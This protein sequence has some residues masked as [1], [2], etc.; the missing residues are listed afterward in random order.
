MNKKEDSVFEN[1]IEEEDI[2][3]I[4]EEDDDE[5]IEDEDID[6]GEEVLEDLEDIDDEEEVLEDIEDDILVDLDDLINTI[7]EEEQEIE[8]KISDKR[9]TF[10]ILTKYEKVF[11]LG[12]RTQQ[13]INGSVI[14]IDI[15]LL[16]EKSAYNIALEELRQKRIPFK[17]K[18]TLPSGK[19]ELWDLEELIIL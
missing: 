12:F 3:D 11:I 17:I 16:K 8:E 1:N 2:L 14:L 5:V 4:E 9:T 13:I 10:N 7:D 15:N 6:D 18:R 19:V